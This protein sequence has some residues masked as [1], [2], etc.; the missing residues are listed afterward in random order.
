M[1]LGPLGLFPCSGEVVFGV[2]CARD[3]YRAERV[4]TRWRSAASES[5]QMRHARLGPV[6]K[7]WLEKSCPEHTIQAALEALMKSLMWRP[8]GCLILTTEASRAFARPRRRRG[9]RGTAAVQTDIEQATGSLLPRDC[10]VVAASSAGVLGPDGAELL[11]SEV[12][13]A[14]MVFGGGRPPAL[15]GLGHKNSI[16]TTIGGGTNER[17][18]RR[19]ARS[20]RGG[21]L[22]RRLVDSWLEA[23]EE[24]TGLHLILHGIAVSTCDLGL[25]GTGRFG[26]C[27]GGFV[28]GEHLVAGRADDLQHVDM[29]VLSC[30][31]AESSAATV[32]EDGFGSAVAAA[33]GTHHRLRPSWGLVV[34]CVAL[35]GF[36]VEEQAKKIDLSDIPIVG[37]AANGEIGPRAAGRGE[38]ASCAVHSFS[39]CVALVLS[40]TTASR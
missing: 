17:E 26:T 11:G 35:D 20:G 29:V 16:Q 8:Q 9:E 24:P 30:R 2:L 36:D 15:L 14:A 12:G 5:M 40:N 4:C 6:G 3:V 39:T 23:L 38:G 10:V 27:V 21:R 33:L 18:L 32:R 37:F 7:A 22:G 25:L 1:S 28:T 19:R 34:S 31:G 13:V